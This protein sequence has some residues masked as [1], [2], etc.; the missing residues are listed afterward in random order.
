VMA[1]EVQRTQPEAV[2]RDPSGYLKVDYGKVLA[3][4]MRKGGKRGAQSQ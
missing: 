4:A 3:R 2:S 1:Q